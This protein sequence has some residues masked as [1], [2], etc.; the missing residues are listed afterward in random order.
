MTPDPELLRRYAREGDEAAFAEL[1]RRHVDLVYGAAVRLAHG[2]TALAEDATQT[3]FT[4]LARKAGKLLRHPTLTGWLHTSAWYATLTAVRQEQTRRNLEQEASAMNETATTPEDN[5]WAQLR[6]LL[7]E[8]LGHLRERE[9]DAVLLRFFQDKNY[10]EVGSILGVSEGAAQMRV[11]RALEK[12]RGRFS[13]RGVVTTA[14]LLVS[15]LGAH[16]ASTPVPSSFTGSITAK[17]LANASVSK[18]NLQTQWPIPKLLRI[19]C[20]LT[21]IGLIGVAL[22][23]VER[24]HP[25]PADA[26]LNLNNSLGKS[27]VVAPALKPLPASEN[28]DAERKNDF[29]KIVVTSNKDYS[30]PL[31]SGKVMYIETQGISGNNVIGFIFGISNSKIS[32]AYEFRFQQGSWLGD[33]PHGALK[34]EEGYSVEVPSG[35]PIVETFLNGDI[36]T[37]TPV[38]VKI[39]ENILGEVVLIP[40]VPQKFTLHSGKIYELEFATNVSS[41]EQHYSVNGGVL[42][43]ALFDSETDYVALGAD[44]RDAPAEAP[45]QTGE[46]YSFKLNGQETVSFTPR[47]K[48]TR[49]AVGN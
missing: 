23:S 16:G 17:S 31:K 36:V 39:D 46:E 28:N 33:N 19:F 5:S 40:D 4:D 6:P 13:R 8:A 18:T 7:D 11:E 15:A 47:Y 30:F 38:S 44:I 3:V 12:L 1:V 26:S 43:V 22:F 37:F 10:R 29:G 41:V 27:Y 20:S 32:P 48:N 9:R 2:N 14:A 35:T 25:L 45:P 21:A 49:Q 42:R 24:G 34:S